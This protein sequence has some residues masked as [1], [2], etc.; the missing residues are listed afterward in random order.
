MHNMVISKHSNFA[1]VRADA[2][3]TATLTLE[4]IAEHK[5]KIPTLLSLY[6]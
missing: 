6:T 2:H 5:I 4:L 3:Q 1:P